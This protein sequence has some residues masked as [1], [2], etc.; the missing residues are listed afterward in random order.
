MP[1]LV[2][3]AS[4]C[5]LGNYLNCQ[6]IVRAP[7]YVAAVAA[8]L[9]PGVNYLLIDVLGAILVPLCPSSPLICLGPGTRSSCA[10]AASARMLWLCVLPAR[11]FCW[12]HDHA[13]KSA[14][15]TQ[16]WAIL[17]QRRRC[18]SPTV[19]SFAACGS[20]CWWAR[21]ATRLACVCV[22]SAAPY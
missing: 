20:A 3:Y 1:S 6:G 14:V 17:G 7:F 15:V 9:H 8:A 16:A 2:F 13:G 5:S 12:Q 10:A 21:W 18:Q 4:I 19:S 11:H 22:M